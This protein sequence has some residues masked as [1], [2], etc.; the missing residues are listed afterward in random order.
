MFSALTSVVTVKIRYNN[1][2]TET[3]QC[4]IAYTSANH[5]LKKYVFELFEKLYHRRMRLRLIGIQFSGLVRGNY[6]IDLF[7]DSHEIMALYEA[8]DKIKRQYGTHI[9][10]HSATAI[11]N[12]K[13]K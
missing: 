9:I 13:K 1:F 8:I 11:S 12:N 3:K 10:S 4:K 7:E 6:Q 2:D 5:I